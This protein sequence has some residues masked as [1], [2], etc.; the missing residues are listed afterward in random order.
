MK[1][2]KIALLLATLFF[3]GVCIMGAYLW[4]KTMRDYKQEAQNRTQPQQEQVAPAPAE[5]TP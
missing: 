1:F 2:S 4:I 3:F 5:N